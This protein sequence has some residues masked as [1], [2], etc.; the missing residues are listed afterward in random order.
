VTEIGWCPILWEHGEH[1]NWEKIAKKVKGYKE[2]EERVAE[3]MCQRSNCEHSFPKVG[4]AA[5]PL[6]PFCD[7]VASQQQKECMKDGCV[8]RRK[9]NI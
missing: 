8:Q 7:V 6:L 3:E 2:K 9:E 4:S 5:D 1:K